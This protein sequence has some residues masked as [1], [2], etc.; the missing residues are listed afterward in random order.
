MSSAAA[1]VLCFEASFTSRFGWRLSSLPRLPP[2]KGLLKGSV[3]GQ[4]S[5][6]KVAALTP[7]LDVSKQG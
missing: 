6:T 7:S 2:D 3:L 5:L 1:P 4:M